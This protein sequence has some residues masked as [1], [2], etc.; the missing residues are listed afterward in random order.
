MYACISW[1]VCSLGKDSRP[2]TRETSINVSK[3]RNSPLPSKFSVKD[4]L[5]NSPNISVKPETW[6]SMN[7]QTTNPWEACSKSYSRRMAIRMI[8]SMIGLFSIRKK[9]KLIRRIK[10]RKN[11]FIQYSS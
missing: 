1:E 7:D 9:I 2:I 3:K 4:I 8:I 10:Q 5:F 6:D 11:D